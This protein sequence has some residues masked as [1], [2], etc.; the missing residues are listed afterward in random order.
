MEYDYIN[1]SHYKKDG[2]E[3]IDWLIEKYGKE[4]VALWCRITA[5]K[6]EFRKGNKPNE[7]IERENAKI[8]WYLNKAEELEGGNWKWIKLF[9]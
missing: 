7:S 6:Y 2:K 1:P 3:C 9:W 4:A 5:D 8:E